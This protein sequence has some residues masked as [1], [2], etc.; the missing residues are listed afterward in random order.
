MKEHPYD[1]ARAADFEVLRG[2]YE[3]R[4]RRQDACRI[5]YSATEDWTAL[6]ELVVDVSTYSDRNIPRARR[7]VLRFLDRGWLTFVRERLEPF[8]RD[9]VADDQARTE[10]ADD[11][12][13]NWDGPRNPAGELMAVATDKGEAIL[14]AHLVKRPIHRVGFNI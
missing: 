4:P 8:E 9:D 1:P 2:T 11:E 7:I 12:V 6:W 13:W 14:G 3:R 5:L 10:L